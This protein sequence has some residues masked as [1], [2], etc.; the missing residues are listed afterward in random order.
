MRSFSASDVVR[1]CEWGRDKHAL[2]RALVLLRA[3]TGAGRAAHDALA[4]LPIGRRDALLLELRVRTFGAKFDFQAHC[5]ECGEGIEWSVSADELQVA[6]PGDG[7]NG[8]ITVGQ[9]EVEYRLPDSFDLAA[10]AGISDV[11]A[12]R[13]RLF[14]R[15][16]VRAR[17]G[18]REVDAASL[19]E[20]VVA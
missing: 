18:D 5:P 19:P 14:A 13:R 16:V 8:T 7:A 15:C 3:A 11:R 9:H 2:D 10:V 6:P 17:E 20:E 12:A 4:R 1:L